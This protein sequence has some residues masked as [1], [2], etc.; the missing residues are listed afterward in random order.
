MT[1]TIE[2]I[3]YS[4]YMNTRTWKLHKT[5]N[6]LISVL[7]MCTF[8]LYLGFLMSKKGQKGEVTI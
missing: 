1:R 8:Y 2:F 6:F 5:N 3:V 4:L 7:D